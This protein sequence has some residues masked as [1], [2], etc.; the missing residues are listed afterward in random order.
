[1][2]VEDVMETDLVTCDAGETLRD[3]VRRMLDRHVGSVIVTVDGDPAGILTE[4]DALAAGY[5]ADRRFGE[6]P[7]REV[8]SATS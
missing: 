1:M 4:T 3:A 5:V 8:A 7:V 2:L 6:I